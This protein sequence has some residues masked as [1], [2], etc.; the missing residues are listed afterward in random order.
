MGMTRLPTAVA[1]VVMVRPMDMGGSIGKMERAT[2]AGRR[3]DYE[4]GWSEGSSSLGVDGFLFDLLK[5]GRWFL[6][7]LFPVFGFRRLEGVMVWCWLGDLFNL[8]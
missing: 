8:R 2:P 7:S 5:E 3:I 6:L 1:A 4:D